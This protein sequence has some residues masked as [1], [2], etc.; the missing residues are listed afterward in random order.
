MVRVL[1]FFR[2]KELDVDQLTYVEA[3]QATKTDTVD[4]EGMGDLSRLRLNRHR[5]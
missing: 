5:R 4:T 3:S 2:K 1:N